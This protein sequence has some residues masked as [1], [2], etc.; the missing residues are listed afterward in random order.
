MKNVK[1][2]FTEEELTNEPPVTAHDFLVELKPIL[3]DF[4]AGK[5]SIEGNVIMYYLLNGQTFIIKATAVKF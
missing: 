2:K 4:F 3:E 5:I 1:Q